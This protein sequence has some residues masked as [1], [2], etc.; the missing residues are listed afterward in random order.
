MGKCRRTD[1]IEFIYNTLLK[2]G[3]AGP[4]RAEIPHRGDDAVVGGWTFSHFLMN[5]GEM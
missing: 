1:D 5:N 2:S 3:N 4:G